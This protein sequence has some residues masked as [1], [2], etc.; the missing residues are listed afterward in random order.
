MSSLTV[1]CGHDHFLRPGLISL[2]LVEGETLLDQLLRH[3]V[4]LP[5]ECEAVGACGT[6][7][8]VVREGFESLSPPDEDERDVLDKSRAVE[9]GSRLACKVTAGGVDLAIEIAGGAAPRTGA[10]SRAGVLPV[11]LSARAARHIAAH[12]ATRGAAAAVR[13][14]VRPAG[15]SGFR[16]RLDYAD[17]IEARDTVFESR[18][19]RIVVDLESLPY[20]QGTTL[21]L[22]QDGLT[23]KLRFDNPNARRTCGCG[24]SFGA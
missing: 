24:E 17:A 2:P 19:I 9:P 23:R 14:G 4:D 11:A 13:L 3:D 1:R 10:A 5:H 15:C 8:I 16:Y 18:G 21:D 22:A 12:L 6:C 7:V 20:I